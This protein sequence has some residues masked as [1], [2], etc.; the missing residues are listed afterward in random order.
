MFILL[1]LNAIQIT[2]ETSL[3]FLNCINY[4]IFFFKY[5]TFQNTDS[6]SLGNRRILY[7]SDNFMQYIQRNTNKMG[8][9][10][11]GGSDRKINNF[12]VRNQGRNPIL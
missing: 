11:G 10:L 6:I 2:I 8:Q 3:Y 7:L 12:C 1:K 5:F 9:T 4:Q